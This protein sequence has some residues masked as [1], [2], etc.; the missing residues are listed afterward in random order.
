MI[1]RKKYYVLSIWISKNIGKLTALL[2]DLLQQLKQRGIMRLKLWPDKRKEV[3]S[4]KVSFATLGKT[5]LM[6]T[7][8]I[9]FLP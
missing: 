1:V 6:I 7:E 9:V 3:I 2:P 8:G 5:F 4:T